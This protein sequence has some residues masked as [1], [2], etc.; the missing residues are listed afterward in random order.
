MRICIYIFFILVLF[1]NI[2]AQEA[3]PLH[4]DDVKN[5]MT[6]ILKQHVDQKD[7]SEKIVKSSFKIYIDQFDPDRIYLLENE[8][9]P[10]I[11]P[12]KQDINA[13]LSDWKQ[14]QFKVYERLN[15]LIEKAIVRAQNERKAFSAGSDESS[16]GFAKNLTEL[17]GRQKAH[18]EQYMKGKKATPE[19]Y[20]QFMTAHEK[21]YLPIGSKQ[22]RDS[23]FYMHVLK[24]LTKGLDAHT[25]YLNDQ[26]AFDMKI[27]L[28]K[29][30]DGIGIMVGKT[31][32]GYI[33]REIFEGSPALES[34][35]IKTGDV[36]VKIDGESI[37]KDDIATVVEKLRGQVG[38][39]V[40]LTIKAE[41]K[42]VQTVQLTRKTINVNDGRVTY[43]YMPFNGGIV[44]VIKLTSFYQNDSGV[45]AENDIR[46]AIQDLS[47]KGHL[48][49]IVLDLRENSG[50]F[51][52]QAIKVAGL[53]ITNG[54]VVISKYSN[55]E[56]HF[57][58]DMDGKI[59]YDGPLVILTSKVTA[60]AAE[61]VAQALQDYGVALVV[62]DKRTYGKGTIQSQTVT[63]GGQSSY[64]KVT[65]GK[66]YTPSGKTPQE[67]GVIAD[68]IV[69]SI[70]NG[71]N[72][73]EEYLESHLS[74]DRI[75]PAFQDSLQDVEL[76]VRPW[77]LRYYVPTV[78]KPTTHWKGYV[79]NLR[80]KSLERMGK[81][82]YL[83][84]IYTGEYGY[85]KKDD[86]QLFEAVNVVKDMVIL[87]AKSTGRG[88]I[89]ETTKAKE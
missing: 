4:A 89:A 36:I 57:Y 49:G 56:E 11:N 42:P 23:L 81:E 85:N 28:E 55:G 25:S 32:D 40:L 78:Q 48:E 35:K 14:N 29:S 19:R 10:Y 26:E 88:P 52:S 38:T 37:A 13:V 66:Y 87:D 39:K 44:G 65:V 67:T 70:L 27:R 72:I 63:D 5:V 24:G 8:V 82:D 83:N 43:R 45:S 22:D 46:R 80:E 20:E 73:G 79:A 6:Q 21:E 77:Y 86:L 15:N 7:L 74:N 3:K 59:A 64:F 53:F 41:G 69:P 58:R 47:A 68:I 71:E 31:E 54:V 18:F 33:V 62:G 50:G 2:N 60:S 34:G 12:S 9:D 16:V 30:M 61:I 75:D 17:K 1:N 51:L 84:K 76:S